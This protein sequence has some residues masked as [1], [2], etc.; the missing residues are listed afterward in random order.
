MEEINILRGDGELRA[1]RN[2]IRYHGVPMRISVRLPGMDVENA[3][4]LI[5]VSEAEFDELTVNVSGKPT[6]YCELAAGLSAVWPTPDQSY[7][8]HIQTEV[9]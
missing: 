2:M 1:G 4:T 3:I 9:V 8:V 7:M 6:C 5:P